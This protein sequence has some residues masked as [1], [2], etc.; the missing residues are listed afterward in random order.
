MKC[1][2]RTIRYVRHVNYITVNGDGDYNETIE[3]ADCLGEECPY[4]GK[5][6]MRHRPMGGFESVKMSVC[7]RVEK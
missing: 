2:F 3:Y 5:T 7:R 6:V 4:Y 1:P